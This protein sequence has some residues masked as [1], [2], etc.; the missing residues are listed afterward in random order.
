MTEVRSDPHVELA[1]RERQELT[2]LCA[3]RVIRNHANGVPIDPETLR[4][5]QW[6]TDHIE[7]LGRPL[8]TGDYS[9]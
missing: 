5:A 6:I 9:K 1:V 8:T 2:R 4:W 3:A 7:P